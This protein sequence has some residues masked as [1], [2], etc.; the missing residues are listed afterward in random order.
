VKVVATVLLAA[1]FAVP[2]DAVWAQTPQGAAAPPSTKGVVPKGRAPVSKEVLR[3]K[4]PAP[5]EADL[6]NGAHLMVL[7]DRRAPQVTLQ[8]FI[9]GAGGYFDPPGMSGLATFTASQMREGTKR[10]TT[11]QLNE[12]LERLAA[13]VTVGSGVSGTEAVLTVSSL[14]E[15]LDRV[16][17]IAADVLLN[18]TFPEEEFARYKQ[19]TRAG[20][21]QQRSNPDFLLAERSSKVMYGDHP[22]SRISV[23]L[24]ALD[25]VTRA[26]LVAFH[27][28]K[29]VPDHAAIAIS[30]DISMAEARKLVDAKLGAW[31]RANTPVPETAD[32]AA[33][34]APE[35][36]FVARPNSVQTNLAVTAPGISRTSKEYDVLSV[37]NKIIG[38]GPTGRL[39]IILR[40]DKGYTYGAY[41]GLTAGLY[42]GDWS[43]ST[44]VRTEVTEPALRDLM[45]EIARLRDEKVAAEEFE[46][47]KRAMVAAFALGLE[48]PGQVLNYH[49]TRWRYKLPADYWDT[50]PQRIMAVTADQV[51]TAA[52]Q[53]LDPAKLQVI[54]VG[55]AS[56]VAEILAKHGVLVTYDTEGRVIK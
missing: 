22:A 40:E 4:L 41:S 54:A 37:M 1:A 43:A 25:K 9:P 49:V 23:S 3:V 52:K 30:G 55:D 44:N 39:F 29:Y 15:H 12:E 47:A 35:V 53:Y 5:A 34:A 38:G 21:I 11:M 42:R 32:P 27:Q 19:R 13:N 48:S 24:D 33:P 31:K 16:M 50:Q 8:I 26:D 14:P 28:A 2:V 7:E 56:K 51:Q 6:P 20:L 18:P 36:H 45:A 17:D 10:W 46:A